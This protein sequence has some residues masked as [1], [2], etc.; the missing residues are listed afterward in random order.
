[1]PVCGDSLLPSPQPQATSSL[2]P[3]SM[4]SPIQ[5][6]LCRWNHYDN[7]TLGVWLLSPSITLSRSI[8]VVAGVGHFTPLKKLFLNSFGC[9]G[10]YR[11]HVDLRSSLWCA[12]S[13]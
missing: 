9:T 1:M 4:D 13:F 7:M 8:H 6:L 2:L 11:W 3:V 12:G 10:S 5:D